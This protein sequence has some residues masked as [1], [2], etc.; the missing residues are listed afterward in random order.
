MKH[1]LLQ[2][3]TQSAGAIVNAQLGDQY[4]MVASALGAAQHQGL[5]VP[6]L[7]TIEGILSALPQNRYVIHETRCC[8]FGHHGAK[9]SRR[10]DNSS[11]YG[12]FPLDPEHLDAADGVIFNKDIAEGSTA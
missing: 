7:D 3:R 12:Y 11:N 1:E 8:R 6:P 9:L 10:T 4:V 5:G 2:M